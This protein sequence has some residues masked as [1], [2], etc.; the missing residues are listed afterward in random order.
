MAFV[1]DC[2]VTLAWIFNDEAIY[3][4]LA[5]GLRMP[6]AT[7]DQRPGAAGRAAGVDVPAIG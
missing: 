3:L 5:A 2:S 1:P 4:E 7:P 6:L